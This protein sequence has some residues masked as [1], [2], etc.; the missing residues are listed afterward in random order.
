LTNVNFLAATIFLQYLNLFDKTSDYETELTNTSDLDKLIAKHHD[1]EAFFL[2][3]KLRAI[4][5]IYEGTTKEEA[6][7]I[8]AKNNILINNEEVFAYFKQT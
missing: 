5:H 8:L 2:L 4:C 3:E 7:N 1:L 6:E